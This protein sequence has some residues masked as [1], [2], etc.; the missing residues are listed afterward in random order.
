MSK[1]TFDN[2]MAQWEARYKAQIYTETFGHLYPDQAAYE[3]TV[4]I[5]VDMYNNQNAVVLDEKGLPNASPWWYEA[6]TSFANDNFYK[7]EGRVYEVK[8]KV[9]I[10]NCV[11]EISEEDMEGYRQQAEEHKGEE[12]WTLEEIVPEPDKWSEIH[13]TEL[14][15][16]CLLEAYD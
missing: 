15:R 9:E 5:G 14:E 11:G 2:A 3:G 1:Y 13:I 12:G 6:I 8:I 7:A 4:L 16:K 10:V